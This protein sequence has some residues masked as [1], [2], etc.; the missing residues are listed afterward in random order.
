MP[1]DISNL[2]NGQYFVKVQT[3]AS[4]FVEKLVVAK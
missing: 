3:A 4:Q 2:N 1:L